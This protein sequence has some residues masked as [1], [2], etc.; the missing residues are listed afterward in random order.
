MELKIRNGRLE[1]L[2]ECFLLESKTFPEEEAASKE[3]VEIRL[4]KFS[5]GF[6]VGELDGKIITH[7]NSG[8]TNQED[9][10]D[11][12]FK[13]LI[14]HEDGGK[15]IVIFSVAVDPIYQKKGIASI[16]MKEFIKISKEMKKKKILL[17][18]KDNLLRMYEK[19]GYKKVGISAST[20]G[21]AIWYEME[22]SL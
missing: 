12:E 19:M 6:I 11:E 16:M 7:I 20:H 9:I 5:E 10:T 3:N 21:G 13:G 2:E 8:S 18:C 15:N 14:G 22:Q 1:D 4:K 17:L